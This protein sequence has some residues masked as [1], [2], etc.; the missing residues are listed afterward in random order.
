MQWLFLFALFFTAANAFSHAGSFERMYVYYA[1]KVDA[2]LHGGKPKYIASGCPTDSTFDD[3]INYMEGRSSIR[4]TSSRSPPVVSTAS[5]LTE[6]G[7]NNRID[8][9][10]ALPDG[11]GDYGDMLVQIAE[12]LKRWDSDIRKHSSLLADTTSARTAAM[13]A[14]EAR[15]I[16]YNDF[17]IADLEKKGWSYSARAV[18]WPGYTDPPVVVSESRT[19]QKNKPKNAKAIE[20]IFDKRSHL[21]A[22][23]RRMLTAIETVISIL[24]D[25]IQAC[26]RKRA[27]GASPVEMASMGCGNST[28]TAVAFT[29]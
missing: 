5:E 24:S 19:I 12:H 17:I 28:A 27:A 10:R 20:K 11:T 23:H 29:A 1:M 3:Y 15:S 7:Y 18:N 25:I 2:A 21:D 8:V 9:R 13:Y 16:V 22:S 6:K 4:V 26:S 14:K